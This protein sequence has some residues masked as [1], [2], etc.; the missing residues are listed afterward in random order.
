MIKEIFLLGSTGS[1][2]E[3]T[4][5]ILKKDKKNFRVKLLTT[6]SNIK[7][8]YK[9]A[10]DFKVKNVVIFNK[11]EYLKN[12]KKFKLKKINVFSSINWMYSKQKE[13]NHLYL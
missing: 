12:Y 4:L 13:K 8:I 3:T 6:N 5:N 11:K 7:K 10:I 1:I 9:Q 2:G